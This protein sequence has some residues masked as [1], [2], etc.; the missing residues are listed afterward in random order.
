MPKLGGFELYSRIRSLDD[1]V[2]VCFLTAGEMHYKEIRQ[3]AFPELDVNC[4]IGM[5]IAN[6]DLVRRVKEV[7]ELR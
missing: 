7:L 2:K 4:F 6:Q 3:E 5:P 1:K